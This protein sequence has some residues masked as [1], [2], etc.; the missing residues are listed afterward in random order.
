MPCASV[1]AANTSIF[2]WFMVP[3][4]RLT[5][6]LINDMKTKVTSVEK[7]RWISKHMRLQRHARACE[8]GEAERK[9]NAQL[10]HKDTNELSI[11]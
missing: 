1:S 10:P 9:I 11:D 6:I 2:L 5:E 8:T 7:K 3:K 4:Y